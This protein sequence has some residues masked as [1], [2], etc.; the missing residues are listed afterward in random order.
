MLR[1]SPEGLVTPVPQQGGVARL[2]VWEEGYWWGP[3]GEGLGARG[4][5]TL[6]MLW[7]ILED[8]Y[9]CVCAFVC[10]PVCVVCGRGGRERW[11]GA[12]TPLEPSQYP[13]RSG[14]R[15]YTDGVADCSQ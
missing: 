8:P 4:R 14:V 12:V 6:G 2:D 3:E 5:G 13:T 9:V 10:V 15:L 7:G 1:F 11:W